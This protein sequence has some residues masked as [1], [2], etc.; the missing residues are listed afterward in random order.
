LTETKVV[1]KEKTKKKILSDL[2]GFDFGSGTIKVARLKKGKDKLILEAVDLIPFE[3]SSGESLS[4]PAKYSSNYAAL[5]YSSGRAVARVVSTALKREVERMEESVLRDSLNVDESFRVGS[6][7]IV[8]G[9]GR[10]ESSVLG[11]AIPEEDVQRLL[12]FFPQGA[13]APC[14]V[15]LSFLAA[16]DSYFLL[17]SEAAVAETFC[18]LELG[19]GS[20]SFAFVSEGAVLLLGKSNVGGDHIRKRIQTAL[21]LDE[22]LAQTLLFDKSVDISAPVH[23]ILGSFLRQLAISRDFMGRRTDSSV[24]NVIVSGGMCASPYLVDAL[25]EVFDMEIKLWNPFDHLELGDAFPESMNAHKY[26]FAAAIG[27]AAGGMLG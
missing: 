8:R 19:A 14:S 26:R 24:S 20:S 2:T 7:L 5:T 4:V 18:F 3:F 10:G 22:E 17:Q 15:E 9:K 13:P 12:G 25:S 11:V 23:E 27:A 1:N 6:E 16:L 21:G